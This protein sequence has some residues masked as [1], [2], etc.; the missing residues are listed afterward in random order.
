VS[1]EPILRTLGLTKRYGG[2]TAV[3]DVDLS[4][5][6]GELLCLIGPNGA[7]KSTFVGLLSGTL[8]PTSGEVRLG[9]ASMRGMPPNVF[10][11]RGVARK[12]QGTNTFRSLSVRDNL[13]VAGLAHAARLGREALNPDEVLDLIRLRAVAGLPSEALPHGQ[14]QW[15]EIG[16]T[17]MCRPHLLMLDEPTAGMNAGDT[18]ALVDLVQATRQ[19][20]AVLVVEHDMEVVRALNCRTLVMHQGT[21]IRDSGFAE[22]ETD[23]EVRNIY[24]GRGMRRH[25]AN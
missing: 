11:Q 8:Q 16:M 15:L 23:E 18:Q 20:S 6:T 1:V 5:V 22:V 7:G 25:A 19:R 10:C 24:L 9:G 4:I 13:V 14:R 12:F 3:A 2:I 21:L 17:L